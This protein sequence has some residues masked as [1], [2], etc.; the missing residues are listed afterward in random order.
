MTSPDENEKLLTPQKSLS[1]LSLMKDSDKI[2]AKID[3]LRK[4]M[5]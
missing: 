4:A 3:F 5:V 2:R 1:A